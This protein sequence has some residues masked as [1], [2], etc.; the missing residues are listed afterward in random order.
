MRT[1]QGTIA[2]I[3]LSLIVSACIKDSDNAN[4][5][6]V[7]HNADQCPT[8]ADLPPSETGFNTITPVANGIMIHTSSTSSGD[9]LIDGAEHTF[10]S[11]N[12]RHVR[13]YRGGCFNRGIALQSGNRNNFETV[14]LQRLDNGDYLEKE[15]HNG[16][17]TSTTKISRPRPAPAPAPT[18]TPAPPTPPTPPPAKITI[19]RHSVD[20]CPKQEDFG[21][22]SDSGN[23]EV[24][25]IEK[26]ITLGDPDHATLQ[27][28][29]TIQP[30][31]KQTNPNSTYAGGC[32]AKTVTVQF[33]ENGKLTTEVIRPNGRGYQKT[34]TDDK[35]N[36]TNETYPVNPTGK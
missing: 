18:P 22:G 5:P 1:L 21:S 3:S 11:S 8:S 15:F 14:I 30:V 29:G 17:L 32:D 6:G 27:I 9:I 33:L 23:V 31:P 36:S 10:P 12:P 2:L 24:K 20:Q 4:L 7:V 13:F 28:D 19:P 26:G 35:G 25:N 16:A 34:I